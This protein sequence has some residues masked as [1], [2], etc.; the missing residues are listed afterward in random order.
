MALGW[1]REAG[2][3]SVFRAGCKQREDGLQGNQSERH[4]PSGI[5]QR[6]LGWPQALRPAVR[7]ATTAGSAVMFHEGFR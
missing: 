4:D 3:H 2:F 1:A 7:V 6:R 5:E